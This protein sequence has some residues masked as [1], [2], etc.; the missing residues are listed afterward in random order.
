MFSQNI[1]IVC[2]LVAHSFGRGSA[3]LFLHLV[4]RAFFVYSRATFIG[5]RLVFAFGRIELC[6]IRLALLPG[7]ESLS[8]AAEPQRKA[9]IAHTAVNLRRIID[10]GLSGLVLLAVSGGAFGEQRIFD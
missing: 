1:E 7:F 3:E 10:Q 5:F 6:G 8:D 4:C 2:L 9:A